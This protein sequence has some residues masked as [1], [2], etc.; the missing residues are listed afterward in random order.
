MQMHLICSKRLVYECS[1]EIGFYVFVDI[2]WYPELTTTRYLVPQCPSRRKRYI[3]HDRNRFIVGPD[4][5]PDVDLKY[6][7]V[8]LRTNTYF[9]TNFP[10]CRKLSQG[11]PEIVV[12]VKRLSEIIGA[13]FS[14]ADLKIGLITSI[15][16]LIRPGQGFSLS[17][18]YMTVGKLY[19][20][21]CRQGLHQ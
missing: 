20:M 18:K 19:N 14:A 17:P 9:I 16:S 6:S 8:Q 10:M 21:S 13:T 4:T 15:L 7:P 12:Y 3:Q 11:N 5:T 1:Y 2:Y